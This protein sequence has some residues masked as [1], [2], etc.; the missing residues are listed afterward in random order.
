MH[1]KIH[2]YIYCNR[3]SITNTHFPLPFPPLLPYRARRLAEATRISRNGQ[4]RRKADEAERQRQID[5][6]LAE[7]W[8]LRNREMEEAE[9]EAERKT[10]ENN[11]R[12]QATLKEQMVSSLREGGN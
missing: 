11:L 7:Q 10:V 12:L 2:D 9:G 8:K 1:K 5:A 3:F 6:V 4:L